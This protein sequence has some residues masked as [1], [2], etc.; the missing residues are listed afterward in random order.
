[1]PTTYYCDARNGNDTASGTTWAEA[2]KTLGKAASTIATGDTVQCNGV[3]NETLTPPESKSST[4]TANKFAIL[5]GGASLATGISFTGA[6]SGT[7]VSFTGF[8][9]INY[10]T[11]GVLTTQTSGDYNAYFTDCNIN[12]CGAY[13]IFNEAA[14]SGAA[15]LYLTR[16][17]FHHCTSGLYVSTLYG[18][19][20]SVIACTFADC[21]YG[22]QVNASNKGRIY[23]V[24]NCVFANNTYH[25]YHVASDGWLTLKDYNVFD[26][27][28]GKNAYSGVDKTTLAAWQAAQGQDLNSIDAVPGFTDRAKYN[29]GLS[30]ASNA[31]IAG[32]VMGYLVNYLR[33]GCSNNVNSAIWTGAT[34]TPPGAAAVNG[35]GNWALDASSSSAVVEFE[36]SFSSAQ[37]IRRVNF[38]NLHGGLGTG[39]G[40]GPTGI[41]DYDKTGTLP[42]TWT[43]RWKVDTGGGYGAYAEADLDTDI[44][45]S[46]VEKLMVE[47]TL[48]RDA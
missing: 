15:N 44:N 46:S 31:I 19:C 36:F 28:S 40:G 38:S 7:T 26:F 29:Y 2:W 37:H 10:T 25:I 20:R 47:V 21:T 24:Q 12:N 8:T 16:V 41:L 9:I 33:T 45:Q 11:Q 34:V 13:G 4:W 3:F 1:M 48:R 32:K 43:Y 17:L 23:S 18:Y 42:E 22:I 14:G 35:S 30:N 27:S 5:D 6:R 39:T